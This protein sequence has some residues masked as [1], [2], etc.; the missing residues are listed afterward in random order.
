MHDL[1]IAIAFLSIVLSPCV[2][3]LWNRSDPAFAKARR[4]TPGPVV[5]GG[6]VRGE[7]SSHRMEVR[8]ARADRF[9]MLHKHELSVLARQA[10]VSSPGVQQ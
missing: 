9:R 10:A 5:P 1:L 2:A 8:C 6:P 3:A 7:T 4:F